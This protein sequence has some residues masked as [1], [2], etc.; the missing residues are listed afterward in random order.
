MANE[1][2]APV[3]PAARFFG[4]MAFPVPVTAAAFSGKKPGFN[5]L[6]WQ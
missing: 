4:R 5:E 3:R 6:C 2:Q 1:T